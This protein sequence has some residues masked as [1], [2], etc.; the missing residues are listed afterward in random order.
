MLYRY[1]QEKGYDVTVSADL[2]GYADA[3]SISG[4]ALAA[5]QWANAE[6]FVSGTGDIT[7]TPQGQATRAQASAMFTR[8][9]ER[10]AL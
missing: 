3:G 2:S 8:F 5:L 7:L 9:C 4:Y 1:A 6:G 10:Y